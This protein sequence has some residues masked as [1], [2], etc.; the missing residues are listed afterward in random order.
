MRVAEIRVGL[1]AY[2][3]GTEYIYAV[4]VD[5]HGNRRL[6]RLMACDKVLPLIHELLEA[7]ERPLQWTPE[8]AARVVSAFCF[9]WGKELLPP[10]LTLSSFDVLVIIPHY[11]LHGLPLHMVWLVDRKQFLAATHGV[12]YCSSGTLFARCVERN[13]ARLDGLATW[14]FSTPGDPEVIAPPPPRSCVSAGTDVYRLGKEY[15]DLASAF[16]KRFDV[17]LH[18]YPHRSL[19]KESYRSTLSSFKYFDV[20]CAVCHGYYDPADQDNSGLLL[21]KNIGAISYQNVLLNG[22]ISHFFRDLPFRGLPASIEPKVEAELLTVSELKTYCH[23]QAQLVALFGCSTGAGRHHGGDYES[24]AYQWL[25]I[26]AASALANLWESDFEFMNKWCFLF[27]NNW[28]EKRQPKAIA[29][30]EAHI[31]FL[32]DV[33]DL[34]PSHWGVVVLYGDWI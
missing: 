23:T 7:L 29:W 30:R 32:R 27:L 18:H 25:K 11:A 34:A 19:I 6:F 5:Q 31:Q 8:S 9:D 24:F 13:V 22:G 16:A 21:E 3:T 1:L 33:P 28:I 12:T 2:F 26:G 17:S 14:R 10:A 4:L 20:I 15:Q